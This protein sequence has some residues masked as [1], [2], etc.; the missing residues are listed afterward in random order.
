MHRYVTGSATLTPTQNVTD[1]HIPDY[2]IHTATRQ[3]AASDKSGNTMDMRLLIYIYILHFGAGAPAQAAVPRCN[4]GHTMDW[5]D[6]TAL[7]VYQHGYRC[8]GG[9]G[10]TA[11]SVSTKV[12]CIHTTP[13]ICETLH[14]CKAHGDAFL[15]RFLVSLLYLIH[16]H[17]FFFF[18]SSNLCPPPPNHSRSGTAMIALQDQ[19]LLRTISVWRV[20]NGK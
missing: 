4:R 8:D 16:L 20:D 10:L 15:F 11:S 6:T 12:Y 3:P 14:P 2:T 5:C 1:Q 17:P 9:C 19:H 7:P 18:S 13:F